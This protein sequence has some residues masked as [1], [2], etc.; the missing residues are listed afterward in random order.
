MAGGDSPNEIRHKRTRPRP[1]AVFR[2]TLF[3]DSYDTNRQLPVDA[4]CDLLLEV[5]TAQGERFNEARLNRLNQGEQNKND[6]SQWS[7]RGLEDLTPARG[8]SLFRQLAIASKNYLESVI[9]RNDLQLWLVLG[10][11]DLFIAAGLG[12]DLFEHFVVVDRLVMV[13]RELLDTG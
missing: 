8:R 12:Q 5:K 7:S 9:G 6:K 11:A 4:R 13:H 2:Q 10:P 1:L 3:V